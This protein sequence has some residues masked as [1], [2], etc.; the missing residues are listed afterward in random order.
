MGGLCGGRVWDEKAQ[1]FDLC[2]TQQVL[3]THERLL[4]LGLMDRW[5]G[6]LWGAW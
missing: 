4:L 3:G 5:T 6:L 1:V 2:F